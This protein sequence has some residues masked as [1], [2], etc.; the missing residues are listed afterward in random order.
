MKNLTY[1][2]LLTFIAFIAQS[3]GYAGSATWNRN[4]PSSDWNDPLNW[5]PAT[6]P[7]GASDIA[8]FGFTNR[9]KVA[10]SAG[11]EVASIV[12]EPGASAYTIRTTMH[13]GMGLTGTGIVNDS[14]ITQNLLVTNSSVLSFS[15]NASAGSNM[16][17]I[18]PGQINITNDGGNGT[19]YF[20]DASSA[21]DGTYTC[22]GGRT[23]NGSGAAVYLFDDATAG[24]STFKLEGGVIPGARGAHMTFGGASLGTAT[25][26]VQGGVAGSQETAVEVSGDAKGAGARL[27]L[28]GNGNLYIGAHDL[29][30]FTLGSVEGDGRIFLGFAGSQKGRTLTVGNNLNTTFAGVIDD[31]GAKGSLTKA[32]KGSLTLTGANTYLGTTLVTKGTLLISN[33]TGSGTGTGAVAVTLGTLGGNGTIAGGV[34]IGSGIGQEAAVAPGASGTSVGTLTILSPLS[35]QADATYDFDV[36]TDNALADQL[37]AN[38]LTIDSGATFSP[39]AIGVGTLN[40]GLTFTVINNTSGT[41]INGSF[42]NLSD[43][44][45]VTIGNT[46][47]QANYEGGDGNDLTLTVVNN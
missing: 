33:T 22:K 31:M 35:C 19:I 26:V 18:V 13:L 40:P 27:K 28:F 4:P 7:N 47:F 9:T 23:D 24:T 38:G 20:N 5:T 41:P 12:F 15:G 43:G 46:T 14:G 21:G 39:T 44:G 37:T 25:I 2:V 8:S 29:P 32:G 11:V 6:V 1:L 36:D 16:R 30:G 10:I 17:I 3:S 45:T 34:T 42:S